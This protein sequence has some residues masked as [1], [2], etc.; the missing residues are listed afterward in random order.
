MVSSWRNYEKSD[1]IEKKYF[2]L[3]KVFIFWLLYPNHTEKI[4]EIKAMEYNNVE[5][6][7]NL[8]L[9]SVSSIISFGYYVNNGKIELKYV[10]LANIPIHDSFIASIS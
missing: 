10:N 6:P 2:N 5:F 8:S 4:M 7:Q 1:K 9:F 3:A